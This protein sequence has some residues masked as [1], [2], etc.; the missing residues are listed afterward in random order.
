MEKYYNIGDHL[1]RVS[2][3]ELLQALHLLPEFEIFEGSAGDPE[4]AVEETHADPPEVTEKLLDHSYEGAKDVFGLTEDGYIVQHRPAG[5][6]L[7]QF[8]TCRPERI[9]HIN[10]ELST[11]GV[12]A[13]LRIAYSLMTSRQDTQDTHSSCIVYDGRAVCFLGKSGTGKSTHTRLWR[14]NIA[15][16]KLLNDDYPILRFHEGQLWAYGS[17]WSGKT[18]CY[19]QERY[20]VVAVVR[21]AQAADNHIFSLSGLQAVK[22]LL[23][24]FY[25]ASYGDAPL[26]DSAFAMMEKI[27]ACCPVY[28]LECRPDKDAA[29]LSF[30]TIFPEENFGN[31][32]PPR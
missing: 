28:R 13:L 32:A 6:G 15:G 3:E 21:L 26:R 17:P 30:H 14:E 18:P 27:M 29:L 2:G 22:H 16:C 9:V 10:G 31:I 4:F 23:P 12:K 25:F 7:C 8:W 11:P 24:T 5:L 19:L 1:F 20:P